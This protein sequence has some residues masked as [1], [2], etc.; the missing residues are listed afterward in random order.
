MKLGMQ[1]LV[2]LAIDRVW[3]SGSIVVTY[4]SDRQEKTYEKVDV[5]INVGRVGLR[6]PWDDPP[7]ELNVTKI[8]WEK[9]PFSPQQPF[10]ANVTLVS[11]TNKLICIKFQDR[12]PRLE[13]W[14]SEPKLITTEAGLQASRS[15][16]W[17]AVS[18]GTG[19]FFGAAGIFARIMNLGGEWL[20]DAGL[21]V[22][23]FTIAL[24]VYFR[25]RAG[26]YE[27][28]ALA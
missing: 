4:L 2:S 8:R 3:V 27:L 6:I 5:N 1:N 9:P 21:A 17:A 26:R 20:S 12:Q 7:A 22:M 10:E 18:S 15:Y 23:V 28:K 16:T 19:L 14:I 24:F 11:Q 25:W 13:D